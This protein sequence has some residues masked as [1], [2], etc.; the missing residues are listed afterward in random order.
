MDGKHTLFVILADVAKVKIRE[1]LNYKSKEF[2]LNSIRKEI[3]QSRMLAMS[4]IL[5]LYDLWTSLISV[6][7]G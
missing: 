1:K 6:F 3:W 2:I 5:F 4:R 7:F